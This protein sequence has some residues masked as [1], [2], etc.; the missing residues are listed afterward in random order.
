M[1]NWE[2]TLPHEVEMKSKGNSMTQKYYTERL[3]PVYIRAVQEARIACD[4][5][6]ILQ[7]D[8]NP[9]HGT[10]SELNVAK[11]LRDSNWITVL[12]HPAQS[13]DL[14]PIEAIWNILK[15]RVRRR[16]WDSL[17]QLKEVL[18]DEWSKINMEEVQARI[19]EMPSRCRNLANSDGEAIK[20]SLW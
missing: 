9:S 5:D 13:P 14:N 2:A 7:E 20:S 18:Q 4:R 12:V 10:R 19:M 16:R 11:Q 3:L 1:V 6:A 15:Q 8:N 17:E